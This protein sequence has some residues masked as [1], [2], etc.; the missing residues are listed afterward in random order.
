[1]TAGRT[2]R[3]AVRSRLR[4]RDPVSVPGTGHQGT[5][6]A[7][8]MEPGRSEP[9]ASTVFPS[10]RGEEGSFHPT[11]PQD[12]VAHPRH[13]EADHQSRPPRWATPGRALR[14]H[15]HQ[16]RARVPLTTWVAA[17]GI[18]GSLSQSHRPHVANRTSPDLNRS[19]RRPVSLRPP[20]GLPGLVRSRGLRYRQL[21]QSAPCWRRDTSQML[22]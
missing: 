19:T 18:E 22:V 15:A 4:Q 12:R 5:M 16:A 9:P 7:W 2:A 17:P 1:M 20:E 3:I 6:V 13:R 11:A 14:T 8:E 10:A 21:R